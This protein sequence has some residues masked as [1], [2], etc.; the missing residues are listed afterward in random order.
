MSIENVVPEKNEIAFKWF[1]HYAGVTVK[2]PTRTLVIDPVDVSAKNFTTIDAILITHEHY[3]H[4]DGPLI[5]NMQETTN[6]QILAD[7]TSVK[8][9]SNSIPLEKLVEMKPG[10]ETNI[11]GVTVR[12]EMCN[13]SPAS[14]PITFLITSE[15]GVR[16]F[17]TA[18]S[19]PFP[20]MKDIGEEH[21]PDVVFCTVGIAPGTSPQT[22]IEIAKLVKPKVAVPYHTASKDD[23]DS[24]CEMLAKEMPRVKCLI[25][26]RGDA[27]IVGKGQKKK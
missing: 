10:T 1:N 6:C 2:T 3:D 7:S 26:K 20:E 19:V 18:D 22:G 12:A 4:L 5:R 14:T 23:L 17:H 8:K 27:Y 21:R 11:G 25:A 16:I 9:L 13:H 24:F 15:D